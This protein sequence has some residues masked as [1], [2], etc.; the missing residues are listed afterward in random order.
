VSEVRVTRTG[1]GYNIN[2]DP[3]LRCVID[4]YTLI[5]PGRGYTS[6]PDV[7]VDGVAGR[8][9]AVIDE[10]GYLISIQPTDRT[11]TWNEIPQVRII[12]GG[13]SGARVIPSVTCLDTKTYEDQGYAKIG[14]G[15]YIDCP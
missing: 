10:R 9:I 14:T 3:E 11:S 6:T 12:G 1:T 2:Q 4:S 5:N 7:Y 13:G 8:A 15:K